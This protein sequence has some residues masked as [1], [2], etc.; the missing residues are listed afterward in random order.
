MSSRSLKNDERR[1]LEALFAAS[2]RLASQNSDSL[3][4]ET[5]DDGGMGSVRLIPE[6]P[7]A[8]DR[9]FGSAVSECRFT[10]SDGVEVFATLYLDRQ[11]R[12]FEL[13]IWKTDFAPLVHVPDAL[14]A[15]STES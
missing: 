11:D 10:D 1:L 5:L 8:E 2:T 9:S 12:P 6:G 3:R 15:Q 4:V 7:L 14:E 13:N